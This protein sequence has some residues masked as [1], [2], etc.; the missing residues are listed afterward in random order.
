MVEPDP[1]DH[2]RVFRH[3]VETLATPARSRHAIN[4]LTMHSHTSRSI[5]H[6]PPYTGPQD[7]NHSN[8]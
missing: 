1:T 6:D 8:F 3:P 4:V 7:R 5:A 2:D